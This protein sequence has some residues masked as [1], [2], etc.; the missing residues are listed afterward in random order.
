M[1]K[2]NERK[3]ILKQEEETDGHETRVKK[4]NTVRKDKRAREQT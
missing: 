2:T 1:K 3:R 4:Q